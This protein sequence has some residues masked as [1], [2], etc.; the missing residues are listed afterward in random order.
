MIGCGVSE[1]GGVGATTGT[2]TVVLVCVVQALA[3]RA[4]PI[5][6]KTVFE[7]DIDV[8]GTGG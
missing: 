3:K 5:R 1:L 2:N 6:V 4:A 8:L 7:R